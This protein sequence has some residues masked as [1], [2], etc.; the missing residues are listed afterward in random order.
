MSAARYA[1]GQKTVAGGGD[2]AGPEGGCA[3][4]ALVDSDLAVRRLNKDFRPLGF[5]IVLALPLLAL[6]LLALVV[7]VV[8]PAAAA[9]SQVPRG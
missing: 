9:A 6:L 8:V 2:N 3:C 7:V 5:L 4:S 1:S